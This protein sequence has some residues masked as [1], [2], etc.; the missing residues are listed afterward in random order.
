MR[1]MDETDRFF[2]EKNTVYHLSEEERSQTNDYLEAVRAFG[3]LTSQ[4]LYIIDYQK[5]NFEYVSDSPLFLCGHTPQEVLEMGYNF[6]F[7]NVKSEDLDLLLTINE[8]GFSFYESLPV[9]ERKLYSISY[10]FHLMDNGK[11]IL[12]NQQLTPIYLTDDGKIWK[13]MCLIS[14]SAKDR[15]GN[16]CVFKHGSDDFWHFDRSESSWKREQKAQLTDRE[17]EILRLCVRGLSINEIA[18]RVCLTPDTVKF[19]RRKLFAKIGAQNMTEALA[20]ATG[21]K[22]M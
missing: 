22:L 12:V 1:E 7:R 14:L 10:D 21:N 17:T 5:K 6:Y 19:H 9:E 16:I 13:A 2:M 20:Y 4:S 18:L 15:A 3:R 8:V 11:E